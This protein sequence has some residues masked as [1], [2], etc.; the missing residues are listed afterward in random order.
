[1][2]SAI[3]TD[4]RMPTER[5]TADHPRGCLYSFYLWVEGMNAEIAAVFLFVKFRSADDGLTTGGSRDRD[6]IHRNV[7]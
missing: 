4:V 7:F 5:P 3:A 6:V 2:R 1:M